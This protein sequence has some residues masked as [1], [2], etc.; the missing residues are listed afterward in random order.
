M[1]ILIY[2]CVTIFSIALILVLEF[3]NSKRWIKYFLFIIPLVLGIISIIQA[4]FI[5]SHDFKDL[6]EFVNAIYFFV[7]SILSLI[8]C[9]ILDVKKA[10]EDK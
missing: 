1:Q 2:V 8:T 7:V 4:Y 10:K 6:G 9:I 5:P 3:K